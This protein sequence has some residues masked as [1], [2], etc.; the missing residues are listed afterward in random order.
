MSRRKE[1]APWAALKSGHCCRQ[2]RFV[3]ADV[4]L[5]LG[6]I[7]ATLAQ[8][9]WKSEVHRHLAEP[10]Q[11]VDLARFRSEYCYFATEWHGAIGK[12]PIVLL[13]KVH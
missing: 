13:Q 10:E 8:S 3:V 4:G 11:A 2:A 12:P 1:C 5:A 6:W 9:Y 7:S